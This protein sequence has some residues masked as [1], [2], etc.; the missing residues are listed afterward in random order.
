VEDNIQTLDAEDFFLNSPLYKR[1]DINFENPLELHRLVFFTD[2]LDCYCKSCGKHRTFIS[3]KNFSGSE[4]L[5]V[6]VTQEDL[7]IRNGYDTKFFLNK[8]YNVE[9]YCSRSEEHR[10]WFTICITDKHIIKIGQYPSVADISTPE[11]EK[12]KKVL[13]RE[14]YAELNRAVGLVTHGIGIG[15]FV[16]LRRI[17]EDLI[18]EAHSYKKNQ[19]DWDEDMYSRSRMNEKI[20]LLSDQLPGFLVKNKSIYGILSI[21]IHELTEDDCLEYFSTVKLGIELILDEKIQIIE[22]EEKVKNTQQSV[23]KILEK[24]NRDK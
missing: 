9:L 2:K 16:Y 5:D 11:L 21:G 6:D 4:N 14:K 17:F 15:S 19:E 18:E 7:F 8:F 13:S 22:K 12:Y 23:N 1:L 24:I 20:E 3:Y 10:I